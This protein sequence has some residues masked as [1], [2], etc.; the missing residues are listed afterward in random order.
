MD[1]EWK[2]VYPQ[3]AFNYQF[4]DETFDRQYRNDEQQATVIMYFT[5]LAMFIA[6][7]G[8]FGLSCYVVSCRTKEIGIRKSMGASVTNIYFLMSAD[9]IKWIL[10]AVIASCPIAWILMNLWLEGFEYHIDLHVD[11]F[12]LAGVVTLVTALLTVT[13][14]SLKAATADP[15]KALRYE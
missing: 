14:Q 3:Q 2:K 15:V 6:C 7:M 5:G 11:V 4:L 12:I 10:V 8:L 1:K 13:W 9:F